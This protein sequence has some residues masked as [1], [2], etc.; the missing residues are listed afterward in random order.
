VTFVCHVTSGDL[1]VYS[2]RM[3]MSFKQH[4][5]CLD[6]SFVWNGSINKTIS[7]SCAYT[8][9][10]WRSTSSAEYVN[11]VVETSD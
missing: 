7:K 9:I 6:D 2:S 4:I 3:P 8:L 11:F 10:P 1:I 5:L